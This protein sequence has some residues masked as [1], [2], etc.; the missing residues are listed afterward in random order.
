MAARVE[1]DGNVF[2]SAGL[3]WRLAQAAGWLAGAAL[4]AALAAAPTIGLQL[5]WNVLIPV[6]PALF[7]VAPGLWRNLCPLATTALLPRHLGLSAR[8]RLSAEWQGRLAFASVA[9]LLLI[10]PLR[11][12]ALNN[13]GAG[14]ALTLAALGAGAFAAGLAFE[15]K[16]GW[17]S[18]LCPVHPVERLYGALPALTLPN[19][20][21]ERCERC[22]A[23]CPDSVPGAPAA[24]SGSLP[25]LALAGGF[26]GYVWGWFQVADL[27]SPDA[28]SRLGSIYASPLLGFAATLGVFLSLRALLPSRL[29]LPLQRGFAAA[30]VCCYYWYRLPALL[31]FGRFPGDG[32]LVDLSATL[33]AWFPLASRTLTTAALLA[34][35]LRSPGVP[36]SWLRRPPFAP[37]EAAA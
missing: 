17:C 4:I 20:H 21:C 14:S 23:V 6:A 13:D 7:V 27:A 11:H 32:V 29:A 19:A 16:S 2:G 26:P 30:A 36:A 31:G 5:L 1:P 28:W 25:L 10:V 12:V 3:S 35:L 34:W 24:A 9:A 8:R 33:P 37:G 18:G 15:W 22:V